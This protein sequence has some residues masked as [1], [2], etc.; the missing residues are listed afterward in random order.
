MAPITHDEVKGSNQTVSVTMDEVKFAVFGEETDVYYLLTE[1][2]NSCFGVA[3]VSRTAGSLGHIPPRS[4]EE[5]K[6]DHFLGDRN[7]VLR[8]TEIANIASI[9][10]MRWKSWW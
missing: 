3:I 10:R 6:D 9:S 4:H 1:D 2:L 7:V 5:N 8:M